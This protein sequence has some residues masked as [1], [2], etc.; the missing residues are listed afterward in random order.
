M[1]QIKKAL[2]NAVVVKPLDDEEKSYGS[3]FI[4]DLG[5]E[6]NKIGTIVSVGK[7]SYSLTG[8]LI[9]TEAEIGD[10]VVLPSMGFTRFILNEEEYWIGKENEL[11][12]IIE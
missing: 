9:P 4:P 3:I 8:E 7:G 1:K 12:C 10:I 2:Y 11:L 6:S 5:N